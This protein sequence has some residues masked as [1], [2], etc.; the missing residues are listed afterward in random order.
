MVLLKQKLS[1]S[2][3]FFSEKLGTIFQ[4]ELWKIEN[5]YRF[6]YVRPLDFENCKKGEVFLK[7]SEVKLI[8]L[9]ASDS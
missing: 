7:H 9:L 5:G 1:V 2:F 4:L 6:G 8:L 3:L